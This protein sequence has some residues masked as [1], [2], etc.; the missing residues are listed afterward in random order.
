VTDIA[1][2]FLENATKEFR[3]MKSLADRALAQMTTRA[4]LPPPIPS[5]TRWP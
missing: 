4:S 3:Q 2:H 5:P 1:A